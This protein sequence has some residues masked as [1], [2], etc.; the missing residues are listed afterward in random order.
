MYARMHVCMLC[1]CYVYVCKH[2]YIYS[3]TQLHIYAYIYLHL[4]VSVIHPSI[5]R[6]TD[7]FNVCKGECD[8]VYRVAP[9]IRT[10]SGITDWF[11][12]CKGGAIRCIVSPQ[13]YERTVE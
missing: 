11:N 1:T 12:V 9:I 13:L 2:I 5:S 7:R 10:D 4:I 6:I 8:K 3:C